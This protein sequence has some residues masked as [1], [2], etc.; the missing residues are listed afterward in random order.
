MTDPSGDLVALHL[1]ASMAGRGADVAGEGVG[2]GGDLA[3][4]W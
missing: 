4:A 3:A 2:G 1:G